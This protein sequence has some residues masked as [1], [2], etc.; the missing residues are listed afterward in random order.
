MATLTNAIAG[1]A[2]TCLLA[3]SLTG[4]ARGEPAWTTYHRDPGRS[5]YDPEAGEPLTPTLDWQSPK[6]D[7]AIWSQPLVLGDRVYVATVDDEVYAL[8]ASTGK[9][10]WEKSVGV[11]VPQG[12][13][14]CGGDIEPTVGI[15][16]TP[17]IDPATKV[18]YAVADTWDESHEEAHHVLKGLSLADGEEVLS[19]PVDPPN[20]EPTAYLQR[21]ALNLDKGEV[22]FG[23]GGNDGDCGDYQGA[24]VA[25]PESGGA[26]RF[27][28]YKPIAPAFSGAAAWGTSGPIVDGEGEIFAATGNPNSS[29]GEMTKF[30][31]SDALLRLNPATDLVSKPISGPG[32]LG[33]FEPPT[34]QADS[35]SDADLG[36]AGPE[37]LPGGL[38]FQAGKNGTGYLLPTSMSGATAA[39]YEGP[40]CNGGGSFGGDAFADGVIYVAC[41]TGVQALTYDQSEKKLTPL[42]QGPSEALGPPIVAAGLVWSLETPFQ[43]G[44]ATKLFGL[45]P[46]TG[47]PIYTETLPSPVIDH[48]GSPSAAGG[49][50]FVSTGKSVTTYQIAKVPPEEKQPEE[51]PPT[52]GGT[53]TSPSG[54]QT[55]TATKGSTVTPARAGTAAPSRSVE[56]LTLVHRRLHVSASGRVHVTLRCPTTTITCR[57]EIVLLAKIAVVSVP[58]RPRVRRVAQIELA[59]VRFGPAKGSFAVTIQMSKSAEEHLRRHHDR[60]TLQVVIASPGSRAQRVGA[61]LTQQ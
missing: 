45:D 48:F 24:V 18:I 41:T 53:S 36:S 4:I 42:W 47:E 46:A 56:L 7:G 5:G 16:G 13:L 44:E 60:L 12:K 35:N 9:I 26:P 50:L 59:H 8:E 17:V 1:A 10:V 30:D 55:S 38:V 11:P 25:V 34:W 54:G 58:D 57:G 19:I 49:R 52:G 14:A 33:W 20:S 40:V 32:P 39:V 6:L 21:T 22:I 31:D 29:G 28:Q 43:G 37:L 3:G 51:P 61:V 2:L 15:V 27:W 23:F